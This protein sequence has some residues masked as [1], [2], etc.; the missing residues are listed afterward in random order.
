MPRWLDCPTVGP[1]QSRH[2]FFDSGRDLRLSVGSDFRSRRQ[3]HGP[4][5]RP[6]PQANATPR[7]ARPA[8]RQDG[9]FWRLGHARA[10]SRRY[11]GRTPGRA[12]GGGRLRHQPHGPVHRRR[13]WRE[14]LAQQP[15]HQ[16]PRPHPR[17]PEPVRLPAQRIRRGHRR[18]HHLRVR[19]RR[20]P[21]RSQRLQDRRG[22]CLAAPSP[23][24]WQPIGI[25]QPQRPLRRA[26][27]PGA[28]RAGGILRVL[29]AGGPPTG[30]LRR[31]RHSA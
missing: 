27:G 14:K 19:A 15:V 13:R 8:R 20:I 2:P 18:P 7:R 10:I 4:A 30:T 16:Q 17:G 25:E 1:G 9:W 21:A 24:R 28:P 5:A 3:P 26:G 12:H 22:L 11:P 31:H 6:G 23:S 29:R